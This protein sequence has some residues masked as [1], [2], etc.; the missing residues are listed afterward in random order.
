MKKG[1]RRHASWQELLAAP[2][3]CS[4]ILQIYDSDEFLAAGVGVFAAEGLR[5]GEAVL[6][7]GTSEHLAAVRRKLA[8]R[9]VDAEAAERQGQLMLGDVV[10]ALEHGIPDETLSKMRADERFTGLRWWGEMTSTLIQRGETRA[11]LAAE[12]LGNAAA[13]KHGIAVF[14]SHMC[15]RFDPAGYDVLLPQLCCKHSHVI[16]AEDY[17]EHRLAVNRAIAEVIGEIKGPMLQSLLSWKGLS[18][19]LPSSQM[20]LFWV[21]DAMPERFRDVLSRAKAYQ[22][23]QS[24]Q[25]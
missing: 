18:C 8:A 11:G 3:P 7:T 22:L 1:L 19:E 16:P 4:H 14:C 25:P 5:A 23:E 20:L 24:T 2:A 21:R 9:G 10:Q 15:D 6:L 17:V 13:E 12:D